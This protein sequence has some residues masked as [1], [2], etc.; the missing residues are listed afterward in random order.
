MLKTVDSRKAT[1][2]DNIPCTL[3]KLAADIVAPSLTHIFNG[4]ICVGIFPIRKL[5]EITNVNKYR[6]VYVIFRTV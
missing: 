3:S 1:G 2:L 5:V 6:P 4:S